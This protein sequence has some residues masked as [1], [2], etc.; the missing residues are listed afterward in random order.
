V[1]RQRGKNR[2][3]KTGHTAGAREQNELSIRK[4]DPGP[5]AAMENSSLGM[6]LMFRTAENFFAPGA[7]LA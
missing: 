6:W 3:E 7:R 1:P 4:R 2:K 5:S